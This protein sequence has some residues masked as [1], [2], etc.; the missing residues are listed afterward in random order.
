MRFGVEY[1]R[2]GTLLETIR[3]GTMRE[4]EMRT[5]YQKR[6]EKIVKGNGRECRQS[7]EKGSE[8]FVIQNRPR[9]E[10]SQGK[11]F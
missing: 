5:I 8:K 11:N 7:E 9:L 10:G 6:G 1:V 2:L 4:A 3:K